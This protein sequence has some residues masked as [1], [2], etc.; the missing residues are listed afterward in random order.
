LLLVITGVNDVKQRRVPVMP[1]QYTPIVALSAL[2]LAVG[3]IKAV[4]QYTTPAAAIPP[5]TEYVGPMSVSAVPVIAAFAPLEPE[6]S[7][8]LGAAQ[9]AAVLDV[10]VSTWP[11]DGAA[12]ALVM[13]LVVA[14][15]N[16]PAVYA[17]PAF[18]AANA[19]PDVS[20]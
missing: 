4:T 6:P 14:D 20:E 12:A 18:A 3:L 1:P 19:V 7:A 16:P 9:S 5:D 17:V 15:C 11:V 2:V 13:T 10:A 8:A